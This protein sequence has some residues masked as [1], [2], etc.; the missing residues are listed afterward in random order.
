MPPK[1]SNLVSG[2]V[3]ST[4][5]GRT[6]PE[7]RQAT[8][9]CVCHRPAPVRGDG[10][11][12]V[13]RETQGRAGKEVTVVRGLPLDAPDLAT[14]AQRIKATCGTGGTVKVGVIELQGN[15]VSKVR[16]MLIERGFTVL[17]APMGSAPRK[18]VC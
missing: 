7:C 14:L 15:H 2:L 12:R 17:G 1:K 3:Y 6:C 10:R 8:A 11:V 4:E 9:A 18:A 5:W 16:A 13:T